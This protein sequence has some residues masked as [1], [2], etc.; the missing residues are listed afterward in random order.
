M[1]KTE[2][3]ELS[4]GAKTI[5]RYIKS[6]FISLIITFGSIILF[7]F[8]I[9]WASLGDNVIAPVNLV[10]KGISVFIGALILVAGK[11]KGLI[12]GLLFGVIYT[13]ISFLIFSILAGTF[14]LGLGIIADFAFNGIVGGIA[15]ILGV[16][17]KK[18]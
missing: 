13:L 18:K 8:I 2:R 17:I 4:I 3:K 9:K 6:L 5:L 12:N 7:A 10:I 11:T 1:A 16:N 14:V 15:G